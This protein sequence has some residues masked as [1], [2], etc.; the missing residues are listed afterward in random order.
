VV[1]DL[2]N[3]T[4]QASHGLEEMTMSDDLFKQ[5]HQLEQYAFYACI[6]AK[7]AAQSAFYW[8]AEGNRSDAAERA[9]HANRMAKRCIATHQQVVALTSDPKCRAARD[10]KKL[11]RKARLHA[12]T[13]ALEVAL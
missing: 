7:H 13:A 12:M 10:C 6:G 4:K 8:M 9:E 11:A 1:A 2:P 5:L 3:L